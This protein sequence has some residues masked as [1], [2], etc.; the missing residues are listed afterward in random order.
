MYVLDAIGEFKQSHEK[1]LKFHKD[2][3]MTIVEILFVFEAQVSCVK[4]FCTCKDS[5][6]EFPASK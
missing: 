2:N 5:F 4:L 3:Q 1:E 6:V